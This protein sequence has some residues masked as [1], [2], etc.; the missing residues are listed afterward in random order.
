MSHSI[1][2]SQSDYNQD[3]KGKIH[4][5]MQYCWDVPFDVFTYLLNTEVCII[6]SKAK[7]KQLCVFFFKYRRIK[8]TVQSTSQLT[9]FSW[10]KSGQ[11]FP[12]NHSCLLPWRKCMII[13][14]LS[15]VLFWA[16]WYYKS[17]CQ[18]K[19]STR[20]RQTYKKIEK[21]FKKKKRLRVE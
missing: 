8:R 13:I 21:Y 14:Q 12:L 18:P 4:P 5:H 11:I 20:I 1:H 15:S 19:I 7:R 17:H 9:P 2:F 3:F 16:H 6:I 10:S